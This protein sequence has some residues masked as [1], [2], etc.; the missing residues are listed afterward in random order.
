MIEHLHYTFNTI[1]GVV[2]RR[3]LLAGSFTVPPEEISKKLTEEWKG[4]FLS[5]NSGSNIP[6]R[7]REYTKEPIIK[8]FSRPFLCASFMFTRMANY[9][10]M[11]ADIEGISPETFMTHFDASKGFAQVGTIVCFAEEEIRGTASESLPQAIDKIGLRGEEA[12]VVFVNKKKIGEIAAKLL[13]E[14]PTGF[15]LV[16]ETVRG[17]KG[18]KDSSLKILHTFP[19]Y[20]IIQSSVIAGA[21]L[22]ADLYKQLYAL[23]P[24]PKIPPKPTA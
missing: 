23:C 22:G 8:D 16:D 17:L 6:E 7:F 12:H 19:D 4:K 1:K 2:L 18:E 9:F 10:F 20:P 13:M 11:Y 21:E 24:E 5:I 15:L 3:R 14:D